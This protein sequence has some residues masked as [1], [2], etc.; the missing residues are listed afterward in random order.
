M[1][2][3]LALKLFRPGKTKNSSATFKG[4]TDLLKYASEKK[5]PVKASIDKPYSEDDNLMH[6]SHE[7]GI[8][9]DPM[10]T[11]HKSMLEKMV[12]PQDAPDKETG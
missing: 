4:R 3:C 7:A 9:E 1:P 12:M 6:I 5:I 8:L 11:L 2:L 10:Y